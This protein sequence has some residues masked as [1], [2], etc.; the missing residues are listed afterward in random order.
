MPMGCLWGCTVGYGEERRGVLGG[1]QRDRKTSLS[2]TPLPAG[3]QLSRCFPAPAG[4]ISRQ[5]FAWTERSDPNPLAAEQPGQGSKAFTLFGGG[6]PFPSPVPGPWS[7]CQHSWLGMLL[8]G[9]GK[10]AS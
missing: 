9:T 3:A 6:F 8:P 10:A 4:A 1:I 2:I 5:M 7:H